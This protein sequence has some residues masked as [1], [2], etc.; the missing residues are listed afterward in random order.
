MEG[1]YCSSIVASIGKGKVKVTVLQGIVLQEYC[2]NGV[3]GT[4]LQVHGG[5]Y[6]GSVER[7]ESRGRGYIFNSSLLVTSLSLFL[8]KE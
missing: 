8:K 4:I 1:W 5:S 7:G 2:K 6:Y 3:A